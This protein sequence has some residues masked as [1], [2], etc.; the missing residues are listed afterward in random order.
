MET[1]KPI[2]LEMRS[3]RVALPPTTA[4]SSI[5]TP[6]SFSTDDLTTNPLS[7]S[8]ERDPISSLRYTVNNI[9][10]DYRQT[11]RAE[12]F[13]T[14]PLIESQVSRITFPTLPSPWPRNPPPIVPARIRDSSLSAYNTPSRTSPSRMPSKDN[15]ISRKGH[16]ESHITKKIKFTILSLVIIDD[17]LG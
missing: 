14:P 8:L 11:I 2:F 7:Q 12:L 3:L 9:G 4:S 6:S 17:C 13:G 15:Y 5:E 1:K 10:N 16:P